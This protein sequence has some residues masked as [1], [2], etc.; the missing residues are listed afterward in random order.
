M[1]PSSVDVNVLCVRLGSG[2][3]AFSIPVSIRVTD[4]NDNAPVFLPYPS[5]VTVEEHSGPRVILAV[6]AR[7]RDAG[8]FGQ[9]VY[10][11]RKD[12]GADPA[13]VRAP[14]D[15]YLEKFDIRIEV[16]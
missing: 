1:G 5:T 9:V 13:D 8:I 12:F 6:E 10:D 3:Q 15:F 7:D 14:F 11:L 2:D 16:E 4:V